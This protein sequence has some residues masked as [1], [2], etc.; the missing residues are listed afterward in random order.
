MWDQII[1]RFRN[2]DSPIVFPLVSSAFCG[3]GKALVRLKRLEEALEV[4]DE[5][6]KRSA[7]HSNDPTAD[8]PVGMAIAY[9]SILLDAMGRKEEGL[10]FRNEAIQ[11]L[12]KSKEIRFVLA[13]VDA[14]SL[15]F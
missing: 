3:K 12:C 8:L 14:T 10:V 2:S 6:L 9:K 13:A 15:D 5:T 1:E 7:Q 4:W 11:D